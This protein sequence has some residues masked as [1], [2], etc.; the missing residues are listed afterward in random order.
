VKLA[1]RFA[2]LVLQVALLTIMARG[3]LDFV[4][5]AF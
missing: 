2:L 5:R 1:W 3:E 4:Y